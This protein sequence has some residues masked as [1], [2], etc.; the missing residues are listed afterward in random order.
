MRMADLARAARR[1]AG[2]VRPLDQGVHRQAGGAAA[3]RPRLGRHARRGPGVAPAGRR[4]RSRDF[5]DG[6]GARQIARWRALIRAKEH[7]YVIGRGASYPT[8]LEAALKVKEV[9]YIHAEG[10]A[11]GELKHGVIALIE[12]G[13][14]LPRLRPRRRDA[15]RH[16][17]RRDGDEGARRLH[18]RHRLDAADAFDFH[19]PVADRRRRQPIVNAVPAQLLGYHLA[20]LRGH[21]PDKPRNLAKSVTVK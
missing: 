5:L 17:L 21:D 9:C 14:A 16:P 1:R 19:I 11:G 4:R 20:L 6:D 3:D 2:A 18:H 12:H 10:F 15:R 13:H 7:L 8:A